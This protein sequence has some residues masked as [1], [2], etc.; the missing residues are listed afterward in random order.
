MRILVVD[1]HSIVRDGLAVLLEREDGLSVVGTA[2]TGEEAVQA[3]RHLMPDIV[4]MDLVL[5]SLNGIEATRSIVRELPQTLV[6]VLSG[7]KTPE[8]V[9]RALRAG[10]RGYVL[11]TALGAELLHAIEEVAAGRQFV[12]P[13]IAFVERVPGGAIPKSPFESLSERERDVLRRIVAGATSADI[14]H[15]LSL[16][17]KTVD[18]YRARMMAKLGVANRAALIRLTLEY[19]LP[20]L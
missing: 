15:Q 16:S 14:A 13:A 12:S 3:S 20:S 6:I 5:P 8:H 11:K 18:T 4:I 9:N 19:E 1:D 7:S 10:A 17:R 2:A